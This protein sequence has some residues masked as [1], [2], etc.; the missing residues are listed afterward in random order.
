[1]LASHGTYALVFLCQQPARVVVGRLGWVTLEPGW[2]I[3]IGSAFGSGG[4]A[5]RLR[6]HLHSAAAPRWH[7]DYLRPH[8]AAREVWYST[9]AI[10]QE[11]DWA[12][13]CLRLPGARIPLA[14]F[15]ASDCACPSHLFHFDEKPQPEALA[16]LL[17]QQHGALPMPEIL[18]LPENW[19]PQIP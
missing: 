3:Y 1:M 9:A 15:G 16:H 13:A 19:Y 12:Q 11:C 18:K 17:A 10:R 5:A 2:L 7:L 6:H 8:L 14:R 4:L